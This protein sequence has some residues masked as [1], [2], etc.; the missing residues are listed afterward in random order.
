MDRTDNPWSVFVAWS[1]V[2]LPLAALA[3]L[4]TVF[5]VA[6]RDDP[7]PAIPLPQIEEMAREARV[8]RPR[9]TGTTDDGTAY[10]VTADD[11]RPDADGTVA[12]TNLSADLVSP[13]GETVVV[14]AG[15][16]RLDTAARRIDIPGATRI[17]T[18][19]GYSMTAAGLVADLDAGILTST[20]P[21]DITAPYGTLTAG[22]LTATL[23][24]GDAAPS[25]HFTDGVKL[26]Y[27]PPAPGDRP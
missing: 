22:G 19:T 10:G 5:L 23:G 14:A 24:A 1:K 21:L 2:V 9:L 7:A 8:A 15:A 26:L 4:S 13:A 12:V 27:R 16:A 25:L 11:L 17:D 6:R 20:G 18:S 3:L